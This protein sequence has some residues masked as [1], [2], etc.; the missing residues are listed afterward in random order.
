MPSRAERAGARDVRDARAAVAWDTVDLGAGPLGGDR[1]SDLLIARPDAAGA[2]IWARTFPAYPYE[3]GPQ[4][5]AVDGAG[6]VI[7]LGNGF[8]L[9]DLG[10]G[11]LNPNGA[12]AKLS[13]SGD[14][15]WSADPLGDV[16]NGGILDVAVDSAG[17]VIGAGSRDNGDAFLVK[18]AP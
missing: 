13:P 7:V 12:I 2:P 9:L 5:V 16:N 6:N 8:G 17:N 10:G 15:L 14:V 4:S 11:P 1:G 18:L 3:G